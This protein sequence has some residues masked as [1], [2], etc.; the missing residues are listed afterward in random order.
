[1]RDFVDCEV[2]ITDYDHALLKI[3]GKEK[4]ID[5]FESVTAGSDEEAQ[6]AAA[7][8]S[9]RTPTAGPRKPPVPLDRG[10]EELV[11]WSKDRWAA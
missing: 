6:L 7:R 2:Y 1:M 4:P 5:F 11:E 9:S 10:L 8:G 3:D